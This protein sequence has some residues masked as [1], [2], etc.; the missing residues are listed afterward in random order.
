MEENIVM[1]IVKKSFQFTV[2]TLLIGSFAFSYIITG[3]Y[4]RGAELYITTFVKIYEIPFTYA[5][6][7]YNERTQKRM[8][9][10]TDAYVENL[11]NK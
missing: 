5:F 10:I 7:K 4:N 1:W 9:K 11:N 2:P 6:N 8:E 3:S